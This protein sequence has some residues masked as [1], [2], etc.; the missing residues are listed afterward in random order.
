MKK[1]HLN[2]LCCPVCKGDMK[3]QVKKT[4]K[5][6]IIEGTLRCEQ[7]NIRYFIRNGTA[8]LVPAG[9]PLEASYPFY[10]NR[11]PDENSQR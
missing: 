8:F 3:L 10:V 2:I 1:D 5:D 11:E 9:V 6:E 4:N 7:C